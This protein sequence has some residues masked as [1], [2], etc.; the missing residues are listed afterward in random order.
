MVHSGTARQAEG[1][2]ARGAISKVI[3]H[4]STQVFNQ[5]HLVL[6][7]V[8]E[9]FVGNRT[10][11]GNAE[12]AR[13]HAELITH[14]GHTRDGLCRRVVNGSVL[15]TFE[16]ESW[17]RIH[18]A[19]QQHPGASHARNSHFLL[20]IEL[21]TP[22]Y[23][24]EKQLPQRLSDRINQLMRKIRLQPRDESLSNLGSFSRTRNEK[25]HPI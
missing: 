2:P 16:T 24:V 13:T 23:P 21:S 14:D 25:F 10:S 12:S 4:R 5:D 11:H 22:L 7:F 3:L 18:H 9:Q 15:K 8:V 17:T 6:R 19:I 1:L 20:G